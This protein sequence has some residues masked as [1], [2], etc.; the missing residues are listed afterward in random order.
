MLEDD[1]ESGPNG[2]ARVCE[3]TIVRLEAERA[4]LP[5]SERREINQ[6]LQQVRHMLRWC[7]TRVGYVTH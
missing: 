6:K 4:A 3:E 1:Q 7:R 5:R 2:I